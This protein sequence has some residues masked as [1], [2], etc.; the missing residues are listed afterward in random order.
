MPSPLAGSGG[1]TP[2]A[3]IGSY[4]GLVSLT[5]SLVAI[6]TGAKS[7]SEFYIDNRKNTVDVELHLYDVAL[8]SVTPGTTNTDGVI[9][10]RAGKEFRWS[11][12][13]PSAYATAI[14]ARCVVAGSGYTGTTAPP[15]PVLINL[16]LV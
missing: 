11:L 16:G 5:N 14:T 10:C 1:V 12:E 3:I 2:G 6:T 13:Y 9:T 4:Y 8:G 7:I 15:A